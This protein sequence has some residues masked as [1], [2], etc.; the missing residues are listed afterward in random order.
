M[1]VTG[2][3]VTGNDY[4]ASDD[5]TKVNEINNSITG[6]GQ[7]VNTGDN[8]QL[9][10]GIAN[11]ASTGDLYQEGVGSAADA[12]VLEPVSPRSGITNYFDGMRIRF[13]VTNANTGA[14]TVN[15]NG[16]GVK[17]IKIA[18]I[19]PI[20]GVIQVGDILELTF[21]SSNDWFTINEMPSWGEWSPVYTA[22]GSMTWSPNTS[23]DIA[24]FKIVG[25]EFKFHVFAQGSLG[26]SASNDIRIGLPT[27]ITPTDTFRLAAQVEKDSSG[28]TNPGVLIVQ[29]AVTYIKFQLFGQVNF[30]T[31]LQAEVGGKGSFLI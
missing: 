11:Y 14:S 4:E 28:D 13:R 6:S 1:G 12:Y 10:K 16:I 29:N 31:G 18:G 17:N 21:D 23:T 2:P 9:I 5:N 7:S 30:D 25:N 15:V 3:F 22:G 27:G 24:R 8:S 26:G 20:L 19:D